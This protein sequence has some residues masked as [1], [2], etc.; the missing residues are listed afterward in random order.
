MRE[1]DN[2]LIEGAKKVMH[3]G[4]VKRGECVVIVT[5]MQQP[6]EIGLAMVEAANAC[7]AEPVLMTM[8][9][10]APGGDLPLVVDEALKKADYIVAVTSTSIYHSKGMHEAHEKP[11]LARAVAL[12]ECTVNMLTGG[13]ITADFA[14]LRSLVE[15]I[16]TIFSEGK[17][18]K[19][20][21]PAGT[22]LE[23]DI[24]GRTGYCNTGMA[25]KPGMLE[26]LPT[27]EVFIAPVEDSVNGTIVCDASCSGGIGV[28]EEPIKITVENGKAVKFEG[29][30]QAK[31]L[32]ELVSKVG[33]PKA[34]QIAE[35]AIGLNPQARITGSINEDEGKYGTCHCA[36][37]SNAGFGGLNDVPLHIDMVQ[38]HPTVEID[39][40]VLSKDGELQI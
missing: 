10:V 27:I 34:Y 11:Y 35:M 18:I 13:G 20:S 26:G 40:V 29:G 24:E 19:F 30:A 4:G 1:L 12:S 2:Q 5:D 17:R 33:M 6:Q 28:I 15:K 37:G 32:E 25:D 14:E 21:T 8:N 23:A 36:I 3:C 7:G 38:Y 31:K 9:Q 22:C 39:G 16:G